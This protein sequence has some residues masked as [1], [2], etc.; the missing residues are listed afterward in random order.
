[1]KKIRFIINPA[2]GTKSKHS[3]PE[4][5]RSLLD[6]KI[7]EPEIIFTGYK[8]HGTALAREAIEKGIEIVCACGGDG[9]VNEIA[10]VLRFSETT[11]AIVPTGSGNGL[12]RDLKISTHPEKAISNLNNPKVIK[13]DT[14][15]MNEIPFFVGAGIG[16]DAHI[17]EKFSH[18]KTRGFKTYIF[19]V[20]REWFNYHEKEFSLQYD[21]KKETFK[22][23][24]FTVANTSQYGNNVKI[25]PQASVMDGMMDVCLIKKPSLIQCFQTAYLLF[26]GSIDKSK[27]TTSFQTNSLSVHTNEKCGHVDGEPV[28]IDGKAEFKIFP[29]SLKV[30]VG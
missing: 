6:K 22:S 11:L 19:L 25:A 20:L 26:T 1:M 12:A 13:I 3:I 5:I 4:L 21:D 2:S 18:S 28:L 14:C 9:T 7:F 24:I 10:G 27:L 17:S 30:M 16:F 8:N 15:T 23:F 29:Q